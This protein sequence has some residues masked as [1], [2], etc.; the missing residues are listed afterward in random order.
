MAHAPIGE[1]LL[2]C[3]GGEL[4]SPIRSEFFADAVCYKY[5]S[6]ASY[7]SFG[8]ILCLLYYGLVT[9]SVH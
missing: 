2:G 1:K 4:G 7:E 6:K 9:V 8:A 3:V 5:A